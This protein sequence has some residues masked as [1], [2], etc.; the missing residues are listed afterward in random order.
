MLA[1]ALAAAGTPAG[2]AARSRVLATLVAGRDASALVA[3]DRVAVP[4][5]ARSGAV[6]AA[7]G[8]GTPAV[9]GGRPVG[10]GQRRRQDRIEAVK[11]GIESVDQ[12]RHGAV[13]VGH[14]GRGIG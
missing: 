6:P 5:H 1:S 9:G 3:E 7:P 8:A 13:Q 2:D 11:K 10:L 12:G 14:C 4:G